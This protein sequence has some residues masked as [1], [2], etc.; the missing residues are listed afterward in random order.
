ME[1]PFRFLPT[2]AQ[3]VNSI[4]VIE[5]AK[6]ARRVSGAPSRGLGLTIRGLRK[7]FGDNDVLRG[8][9]LHIPAGSSSPSSAVAAAARA[10]CCA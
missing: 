10:R 3:L 6:S 1:Q 2:S 9:D 8:I 4:E 7:S 5:Q